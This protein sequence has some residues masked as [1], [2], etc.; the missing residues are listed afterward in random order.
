MAVKRQAESESLNRERDFEAEE[1]IRP[2]FEGS[3]RWKHWSED[4][5]WMELS[6]PEFEDSTPVQVNLASGHIMFYPLMDLETEVMI[7]DAGSKQEDPPGR[8]YLQLDERQMPYV[9]PEVAKWMSDNLDTEVNCKA[10]M[11]GIY[12]VT[13]QKHIQN[14]IITQFFCNQDGPFYQDQLAR[15]VIEKVIKTEASQGLPLLIFTARTL[16]SAEPDRYQSRQY[17]PQEVWDK[18]WPGQVPSERRRNKI[19]KKWSQ[20]APKPSK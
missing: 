11:A 4:W 9:P 7:R 17:F 19:P 12:L 10:R 16:L 2:E 14:R 3:N 5:L 13:T 1:K 15:A 20:G 6:G 8:C 18:P